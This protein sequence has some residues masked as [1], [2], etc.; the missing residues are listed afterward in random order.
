[1]KKKAAIVTLTVANYGNRL[2]NLA[3]QMIL[4]NMG[5]ET[6]TLHNPFDPNYSE[7]SHQLKNKIK[8]LLS[9]KKFYAQVSRERAFDAFDERYITLF[10]YMLL[11]YEI[12]LKIERTREY[13][14]IFLYRYSRYYGSGPWFGGLWCLAEL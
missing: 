3:V 9:R 8:M 6:E 5:Y 13:E 4:E 1:M 10:I 2:Q 7:K 14:K 12:L 11:N